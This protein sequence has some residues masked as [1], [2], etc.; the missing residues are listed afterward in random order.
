[1]NA[2]G[3]D[4]L[5]LGALVFGITAQRRQQLGHRPRAQ[6]R[7]RTLAVAAGLYQAGTAQLLQVLGGIGHRQPGQFSQ[8]FHGALALGDVLQQHQPVR[9]PQGLG[10]LGE[11]IEM[12]GGIGIGGGVH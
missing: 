11:R 9:V 6:T 2:V 10:D 5:D 3:D 8:A 7:Y 12:L 4:F 1:M